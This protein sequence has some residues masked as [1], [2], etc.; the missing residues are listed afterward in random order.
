MVQ[1]LSNPAIAD[2]VVDQL[3]QTMHDIAGREQISQMGELNGVGNLIQWRGASAVSAP[4]ERIP[5]IGRGDLLQPDLV[6]SNRHQR[7]C[8]LE[9]QVIKKALASRKLKVRQ[10][11]ACSG[12]AVRE[13]W[14][15]DQKPMRMIGAPAKAAENCFVQFTQAGARADENS[16]PDVRAGAQ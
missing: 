7:L 11:R 2:V 12:I 8:V 14:A 6:S 3:C 10:P 4:G 1:F 13:R 15:A 16:A 5:R 9:T